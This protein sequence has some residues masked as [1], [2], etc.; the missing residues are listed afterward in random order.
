MRG[1]TLVDIGL[2]ALFL[3]IFSS[4]L[5]VIIRSKQTNNWIYNLS[6][7]LLQ[8]LGDIPNP[9]GQRQASLWL[10]RIFGLLLVLFSALFLV[11]FLSNI[12][13]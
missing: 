10:I 13:W 5:L 6:A 7:R 11:L 8:P 12:H 2:I 9:E 4:G 3:A 1:I